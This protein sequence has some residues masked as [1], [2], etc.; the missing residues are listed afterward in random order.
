[1][2]TNIRPVL[3][4]VKDL[5]THFKMRQGLIRAVDGVTFTLYRGE[6]LGIVGESGC[7]K[8]ITARSI[9]RLIQPPGKIV[10]GQIL[11]HMKAREGTSWQEIVDIAALQPDDPKIRQIR[12]GEVAMVFQEPMTSLSPVHTVG[13]QIT[14]AIG[15][16]QKCTQTEARK[17]AIDMLGRVRMSQ[18]TRVFDQ[19]PFQ[20]SGGMR[21]RV[22]IAMA[23]VCTPSLLI[24]DEP[25]TALDVTT[26]A[27]I[28]NVMRRLQR[29]LG[30]A[31]MFITHNLGVVAQNTEHVA[32]MYLG[33][34]VE[35]ADVKSLFA[36]PKHPYT[37]ALM[38]SI[39]RLGKTTGQPLESIK[40]TIPDP[41]RTP[42]GCRFH[43][44]CPQ[45]IRGVCEVQEPPVIEIKAGQ[46]VRCHLYTK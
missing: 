37:Q 5:K 17:K 11:L 43:A 16:H 22:M 18:P 15:L 40:G 14:E 30:M 44:R 27:Q 9:L 13:D 19:Y 29:E 21:Q 32:V 41:Y 4:E 3:L 6:T 36:D 26:E 20:L 42:M 2:E 34:V 12:G 25:T 35:I 8:S 7:G 31:I 24:A 10:S 28:L 45:A 38:R 1:M 46:Q 33:Q 39:P 23:L